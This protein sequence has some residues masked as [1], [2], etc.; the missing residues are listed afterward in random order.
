MIQPNPIPE[1]KENTKESSS[2]FEI[3]TSSLSDPVEAVEQVKPKAEEKQVE[4]KKPE[5]K[6]SEEKKEETKPVEKE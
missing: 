1:S 6:K 3:E 4:E 2:G 5:E